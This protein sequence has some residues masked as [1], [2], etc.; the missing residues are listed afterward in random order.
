MQKNFLS[1]III[2]AIISDSVLK[3]NKVIKTNYPINF[4]GSGVQISDEYFIIYRIFTESISKF[5]RL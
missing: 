4:C 2:N 1:N 3:V 5:N